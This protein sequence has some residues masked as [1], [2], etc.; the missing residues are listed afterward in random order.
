M[1]FKNKLQFLFILYKIRF[2]DLP[3]KKICIC[4]MHFKDRFDIAFELIFSYKTLGAQHHG[5]LIDRF[6][7]EIQ[8]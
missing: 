8:G 5:K 1:N 2:C 3:W 7:F 6:C 4:T